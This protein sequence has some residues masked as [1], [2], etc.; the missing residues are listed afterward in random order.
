M[1]LNHSLAALEQAPADIYILGSCR[2]EEIE[3]SAQGT[4]TH[5]EQWNHDVA[6]SSDTIRLTYN[7]QIA[8]TVSCVPY[9]SDR[10]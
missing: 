7:L 10:R 9:C 8:L 3:P 2:I 1:A 5:G 4:T 6:T